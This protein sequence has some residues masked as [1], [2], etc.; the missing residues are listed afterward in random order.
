MSLPRSLYL[1]YKLEGPRAL[2]AEISSG[3]ATTQRTW[4]V[5][6]AR[7]ET[8]PRGAGRQYYLDCHTSSNTTENDTLYSIVFLSRMSFTSPLYRA[9]SVP[10]DSSSSGPLSDWNKGKG[11]EREKPIC[12]PVAGRLSQ[13]SMVP[14]QRIQWQ[15]RP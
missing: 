13:I 1:T 7:E 14:G 2:Q 3:S 9:T 10:A 12:W 11:R 4:C 5:H 8:S 15:D 6:Y